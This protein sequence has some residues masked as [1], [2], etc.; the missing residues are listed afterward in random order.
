[1]NLGSDIRIKGSFFSHYKTLKLAKM[2][3]WEAT[4]RLQQLWFFASDNRPD[5]NLGNMDDDDIAL[6]AGWMHDTATFVGALLACAWLDG[7]PGARHL[8]DYIEHQPWVQERA[9]KAQDGSKGGKIAAQRMTDEE[10]HERASK[11]GKARH[12]SAND[13]L[14][15]SLE[16]AKCT[17]QELS[18]SAKGTKSIQLSP[19]Q[20][21]PIQ[22][23][24]DQKGNTPK[25]P[26]PGVDSLF[27]FWTEVMSKPG[28]KL[29]PKRKKRIEWAISEYGEER[30]RQAIIGCA[31]S[32]FHMGENE[33]GK[34]FDDLELI[35]R[36][37]EKFESF[38]ALAEKAQTSID[39]GTGYLVVAVT[40]PDDKGR[41][42]NWRERANTPGYDKNG[43]KWGVTGLME[44]WG[45]ADEEVTFNHG[46]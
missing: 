20:S 2:A 41:A 42:S 10:R 46:N 28:A 30:A 12:A 7:E 33:Q 38:E 19:N 6:A 36:N 35:F 31:S 45:D 18:S 15:D 32:A 43:V 25:P 23:N 4:I 5:G 9:R 40:P 13:L 1:M 27:K 21:N 34:R 8:H 44:V 11:A 37:S 17:K 26:K 16:S 39:S 22:S 14:T 29:S 3:G 24:P